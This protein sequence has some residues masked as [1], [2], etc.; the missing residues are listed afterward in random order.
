MRKS[1][2]SEVFDPAHCDDPTLLARHI[3]RSLDRA[4]VSGIEEALWRLIDIDPYPE[5]AQM[6]LALR[7]VRQ[8]RYE[9]S[10]RQIEEASAKLVLALRSSVDEPELEPTPPEPGPHRLWLMSDSRGSWVS[11]LPEAKS[12]LR[13][14]SYM[15]LL[16]TYPTREAAFEALH[17]AQ[18]DL[19]ASGRDRRKHGER[20]RVSR[21]SG[22]RRSLTGPVE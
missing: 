22:D 17:A 10:L 9:E 12:S 2:V 20:R 16:G 15:E 18:A 7:L 11:L 3:R 6:L 14:W 1:S 13:R 8:G 4:E 19:R 5:R 21:A